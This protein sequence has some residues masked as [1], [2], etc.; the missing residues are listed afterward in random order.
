MQH[1]LLITRT[2]ELIE[3]QVDDD[4][5]A[6]DVERGACLG[7]NETASRI[8]AMTAEPIALAALVAQLGQEFDV[9]PDACARDVEAVLMSFSD[10]GLVRVE[11]TC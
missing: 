11:T 2:A 8:W 7:F 5:V 9:D 10:Q 4:M 1:D 3:T 6:L